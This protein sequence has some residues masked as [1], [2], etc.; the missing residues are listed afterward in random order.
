MSGETFIK[1]AKNSQ[2]LRF[3]ENLE[4]AV[5]QCYQMGHFYLDKNWW[6]I[7]KSKN[8][9]TTFWAIFKRCEE[10]VFH[11]LFSTFFSTLRLAD[12]LTNF[13]VDFDR[14]KIKRRKNTKPKGK[15]RKM[16]NF[17]EIWGK[18]V[19]LEKK[20]FISVV[21]ASDLIFWKMRW[22]TRLWKW[23]RSMLPFIWSRSHYL[24]LLLE[25]KYRS[26][27]TLP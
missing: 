24:G 11:W 25:R 10:K 15:T 13:Q 18:W 16:A 17:S 9:N 14:H 12:F 6:K 7:P 4:L 27:F 26:S 2:F 20:S 21:K 5:K 22:K 8:S 19:K 23:R 3:F 1:S